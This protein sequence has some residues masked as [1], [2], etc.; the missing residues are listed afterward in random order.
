MWVW[1]LVA[2][3]G[4]PAPDAVPERVVATPMPAVDEGPGF[5]ACEALDEGA[6]RV[7]LG[8]RVQVW[9]P[10]GALVEDHRLREDGMTV[11]DHG[12]KVYDAL[13]PLA[14]AGAPSVEVTVD[15]AEVPPATSGEILRWIGHSGLPTYVT[16]HRVHESATCRQLAHPE[17]IGATGP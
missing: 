9:A 13:V 7:S 17:P 16:G 3:G 14:A 4:G 11:T 5:D 1:L 6:A 12:Q 15:A 2:C 10:D 8:I